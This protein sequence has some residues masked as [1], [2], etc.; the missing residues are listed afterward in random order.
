MMSKRSASVVSDVD[1]NVVGRKSIKIVFTFSEHFCL[2]H[3]ADNFRILTRRLLKLCVSNCLHCIICRIVGQSSEESF[4]RRNFA[5]HSSL[6]I[7]VNTSSRFE[8]LGE[9]INNCK[10]ISVI[11]INED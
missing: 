7:Y 6:S 9:I 3:D 5:K 10:N 11:F 2:E 4:L 1:D 8:I